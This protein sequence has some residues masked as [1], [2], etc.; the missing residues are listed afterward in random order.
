LAIY[1][2]GQP[3]QLPSDATASGQNAT[4]TATPHT[5]SGGS[6]K[7]SVSQ[8]FTLPPKTKGGQP[9]S[10]TYTDGRPV[11]YTAPT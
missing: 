11:S 2:S 8:T 7:A 9:G 4:A 6:T 3:Q 1:T 5:Y 10:V